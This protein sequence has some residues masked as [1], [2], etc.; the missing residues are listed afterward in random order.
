VERQHQCHQSVKAGLIVLL[1]P[2][3]VRRARQAV[4]VRPDPKH[5]LF[6]TQVFTVKTVQH[7]AHSARL[8]IIVQ[9]AQQSN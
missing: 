6:A 5:R 3:F 2:L 7:S 4:S 9:R 8:A 1:E